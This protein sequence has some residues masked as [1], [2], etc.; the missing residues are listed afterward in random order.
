L[1]DLAVVVVV[2][3]I[4]VGLVFLMDYFMTIK[5][6]KR[7]ESKPDGDAQE[8]GLEVEPKETEEGNVSSHIETIVKSKRSDD[9][10]SADLFKVFSKELKR[11]EIEV[12]H[13]LTKKFKGILEEKEKKEKLVVGKY[14]RTLRDKQKTET[15][16][17]SIAEGLVVVDSDGK[18]MMMNPTAENL[19]GTSMK[20]KLGRPVS[21]GLKNE[22]LLSLFKGVTKGKDGEVELVSQ[23]DETKKI[24]RSSTAVIENEDGQTVGMVS[25]LSDVTKQKEL[26]KAK[27]DFLAKVSHELRTPIITLQ[28]SVSILLKKKLGSL[29]EA[30]EKLLSVVER[31]LKR[32]ALLIN[33]ILDLSKLTSSKMKLAT[34]PCSIPDLIE[35]ACETLKTWAQSKGI[36]IEKAITKDLPMIKADANRIIQVFNNLVGNAIKFTPYKG[37]IAIETGLD[38]EKNAI[39]VSVSDNGIGIAKE[40]LDK[41]FDKFHQGGERV[42]TDISGT[43]LGLA[44]AKEIVEL[45]GGRIW[46]ESGK[47]EGAKFTFTLPVKRP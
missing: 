28:N 22:Q 39:F 44:I 46:A 42:S 8:Y 37:R 19:L 11:R 18:V 43:G 10:I 17:R 20:D 14:K 9:E 15:I 13:K 32:L 33:E 5:G 25:V 24:L 27:A 16:I 47:N 2:L 26:D 1:I 4:V 23:A 36:T 29:T 45:H 34:M 41:V 30:Q 40:D 35:E 38:E 7:V 3:V 6:V 12:D 31:G 21:D